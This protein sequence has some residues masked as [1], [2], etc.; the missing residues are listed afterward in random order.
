MQAPDDFDPP[1]GVAEQLQDGLRRIVAPNPSPMTYR[2]TNTYLVGWRDIAVIDPGPESEAHLDAILGALHPGQRISH[3]LVTHTHLDHSPLSRA[4]SARTGAPILG[5]GDT[6]AGRSAVMRDLAA[7]GMIGGGESP[8]ADFRPDATLADGDVVRSGDWEITALWT[9]GHYG[10]HLC[11]AWGDAVMCGDLVM[12]WA[13]SLVSPPDGDLTDFMA[14]C[15]YLLQRDPR[16]LYPGHGAPVSAPRDR[17]EWLLAHRR[18]REAQILQALAVSAGNAEELAR[19]IYTDT[20][21][22][23]LPA[24]R[25]NVLA[26]LID[27]TG[28]NRVSPLGGL[29]E[30]AVF[31]LTGKG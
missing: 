7:T 21:P 23:L 6:G 8:D 1:I 18:A 17:L 26:H 31:E 3:I 15:E 25:R 29:T 16:V 2:G 27:L 20:P 19:R 30:D 13:T 5:F 11:F 10:N 9:P 4:L 22:A 14:S 24:A 28:K 12:G